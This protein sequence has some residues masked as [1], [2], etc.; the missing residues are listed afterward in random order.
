MP[1]MN[2]FL[3]TVLIAALAGLTLFACGGGDDDEDGGDDAPG[4]SEAATT[5]PAEDV[6]P[7]ALAQEMIDEYVAMNEEL[8]PLLEQDLPPEDLAPEI[9]A[10]KNKYIEI[11]VPM[12]YQREEM[13]DEDFEAFNSAAVLALYDVDFEHQ[14][15]LNDVLSDLNAAGEN[16]LATEINSLNILTQYAQFELL[17]DQEPDEATRLELPS[18]AHP[19]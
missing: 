5:A 16:D 14:D 12:G 6:D 17:W 18:P 13:S 3:I 2:R 10:L 8:V 4:S 11:F 19:R 7:E 9:A 1:R 15:L